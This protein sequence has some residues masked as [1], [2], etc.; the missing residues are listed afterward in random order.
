MSLKETLR[1]SVD[2]AVEAIRKA[3]LSGI[4]RYSGIAILVAILP[5]TLATFTEA[6]KIEGKTNISFSAAIGPAVTAGLST[7]AVTGVST[8]VATLAVYGKLT[9]YNLLTTWKHPSL[10]VGL[11]VIATTAAAVSS[12]ISARHSALAV[13]RRF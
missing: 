13:L 4:A 7:G 3:N 9:H 12:Y 11:F 6:R 2:L 5:S 10:L 1:G 8:S